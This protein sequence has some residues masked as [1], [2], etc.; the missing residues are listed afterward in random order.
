MWWMSVIQNPFWKH[1][2]KSVQKDWFHTLPT[3]A[4][5][6]KRINSSETGKTSKKD[7]I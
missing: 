1:I 6:S 5:E 3:S 7:N 4:E 2:H